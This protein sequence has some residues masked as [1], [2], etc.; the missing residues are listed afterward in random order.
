MEGMG[1][2]WAGRAGVVE[3]IVQGMWEWL[4]VNLQQTEDGNKECFICDRRQMQSSLSSLVS[5]FDPC[6]VSSLL[7]SVSKLLHSTQIRYETDQMSLLFALKYFCDL[8]FEAKKKKISHNSALWCLTLGL[9]SL[10]W[11][12]YSGGILYFCI[13]GKQVALPF[14]IHG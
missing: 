3:V 6:C 14:V 4:D 9:F 13:T 11:F 2:K 10:V 12:S 5:C 8:Y 1:N 7:S